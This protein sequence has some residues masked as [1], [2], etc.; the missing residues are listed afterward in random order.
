MIFY[1]DNKEVLDSCTEL[2]SPD[3]N[4]YLYNF[5]K[6]YDN[7]YISNISFVVDIQDFIK[8]SDDFFMKQLGDNNIILCREHKIDADN[9]AQN[10]VTKIKQFDL[11]C[12][13]IYVVVAHEQQ[14]NELDQY[15]SQH[16]IRD[17]NVYSNMFW[18]LWPRLK[19]EHSKFEHQNNI[20]K[21]FSL[22]S[23]RYVEWRRNLYLDLL[24]RNILP[25]CHYTFSNLHP[26]FDDPKS[27]EQMTQNLPSYM[28]IHKP[29]IV[30][31]LENKLYSIEYQDPFDNQI[32][33]LIQESAINIVL[34][35]H[36]I[37]Q[38]N[39]VTLTE[40]TYKPILLSRPFLVY[41]IPDI[42]KM[43]HKEG[44]KTFHG[45]IDE[46]YDSIADENDRRLVLVREIDRINSLSKTD[47]DSLLH[48]C[49]DI[50]E[51]NRELAY[52]K[53]RQIPDNFKNSYIFGSK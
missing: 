5:V 38:T 11:D 47:L 30:D 4:G 42:L 36:I 2:F 53:N 24:I 26:D 44:F 10:L 33:Y 19:L 50:C 12:K 37:E 7:S 14:K 8:L 17:I 3:A 27:I 16:D 46:S 28:D 15:F 40:K 41:G 20:V 48:K 23:R 29:K 45:I 32:S 18:L 39:G 13:K 22:F 52:S 25:E 51:Y 6:P 49:Q 43:L 34:E 35:T 9:F 31:W 1:I 21:K